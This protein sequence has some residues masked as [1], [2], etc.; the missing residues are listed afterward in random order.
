MFAKKELLDFPIK[1]DGTRIVS[2]IVFMGQ[3]EP[4][5]NF[6]N[7]RNAIDIISD[8]DGLSI[9]RKRI[10]V[11]TSGIAPLIEKIGTELQCVLAV[12]LHA[13]DDNLRDE[14]VP[15]NKTYP[16]STLI[17]AC[18]KYP[19]KSS[20]RIVF[21][22]VMLKSVNDSLDHAIKVINLI[23]G[24]DCMVNLIPF[25][26][27]TGTKYE[28]SPFEKIIDFQQKLISNGIPTSIRYSRGD[29]ISAACGQ[30]K[31]QTDKKSDNII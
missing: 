4:L 8:G 12:S 9:S 23:K 20:R 3:G 2:N 30:L 10:I 14:L 26:P 21:E 6:K 5:L 11:S 13:A 29:D 27:W 17:D 18:R 22:Y 31:F 16:L 1:N 28:C 24:L 25:N 19:V 15:I 7:V